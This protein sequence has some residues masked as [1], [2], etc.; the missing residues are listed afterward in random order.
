MTHY[1]LVDEYLSNDPD[2][3]P[4]YPYIFDKQNSEI[5]PEFNAIRILLDGRSDGCLNWKEARVAALNGVGKG[6]KLFWEIN[7]GLFDHLHAP[8]D[9]RTQYLALG[10][11]LEHFRDTLWKEFQ[12]YSIGLCV[13]R[14]PAD[15]S[16][17]FPWNSQQEQSLQEWLKG[18]F[19]DIAS[20]SE[21]LSIPVK[22]FYHLSQ[23]EL[24]K[25]SAGRRLLQIFC[26]D[27]ALEF[28]NLLVQRLP[29]ALPLFVLLDTNSIDTPY[30]AAQLI[31]RD[32]FGRL[33][34]GV[35]EG[36]MPALA[37]TGRNFG[38]VSQ[39]NICSQK[40][41]K[42]PVNSILGV[43]V[44][45]KS[46]L[47]AR[48]D[49]QWELAFGHVMQRKIPFRVIPEDALTAEW[50]GLDYILVMSYSISQQG[51]RKL[52][53]FCAAGGTVIYL[54]ESIGLPQEVSF[55]EWSRYPQSI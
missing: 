21:E 2:A 32:G 42:Y 14:G 37:I 9:D 5:S 8:L 40:Q 16:L 15:F 1:T 18:H 45:P 38:C 44:S 53:G 54:G 12:A 20:L 30:M 27:A 19:Y 35:T 6:L 11:S 33:N 49:G 29:D 25:T 17:H 7:L 31:N 55:I 24:K 3:V 41:S 39:T 23:Q 28:L 10:L 46:P 48:H 36:V 51:I 52:R 34:R 4:F 26:R 50:D 22:S 43:C 47:S 13:Y